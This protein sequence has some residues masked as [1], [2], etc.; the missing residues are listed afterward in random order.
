MFKTRKN[1]IPIYSDTSVLVIKKNNGIIS[2]ECKKQ[3]SLF[4]SIKIDT[5]N[6][7]VTFGQLKLG[8][9]RYDKNVDYVPTISGVFAMMEGSFIGKPQLNT[10]V[11]YFG[12]AAG[13]SENEKR[14]TLSLGYS[15]QTNRLEIIQVQM[16]TITIF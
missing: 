10:G 8:K 16:L 4:N 13:L 15:K 9:E 14:A 1:K 12:L 5:K 2:F 6:K 11:T 3:I 7:F